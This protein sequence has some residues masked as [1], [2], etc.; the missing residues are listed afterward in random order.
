[1]RSRAKA[2]TF[3]CPKYSFQ[4]ARM[5]PKCCSWLCKNSLSYDILHLLF[6]TN[7][8]NMLWLIVRHTWHSLR[9]ILVID[10]LTTLSQAVLRS[11]D[12]ICAVPWWSCIFKSARMTDACMPVCFC[13]CQLFTSHRRCY[14]D[15]RPNVNKWCPL[16]WILPWPVSIHAHI[17]ANDAVTS[18]AVPSS[19]ALGF[20]TVDEQPA[21]AQHKWRHLSSLRFRNLH[22]TSIDL[23]EQEEY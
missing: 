1:M 22:I 10:N 14:Q 21:S 15:L 18:L 5:K 19:Q 8:H 11:Q 2:N 4:C 12:V 13:K 3:V 17:L 9:H 6:T 23:H 7:T 20:A 16:T